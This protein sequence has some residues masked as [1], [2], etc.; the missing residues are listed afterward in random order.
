LC[1]NCQRQSCKAFIGLT[2]SEEMIGGDL[3][4]YVN[5][6]LSK[7]LLGAAAVLSRNL[8]IHCLEE[9]RLAMLVVCKQRSRDRNCTTPVIS[10][11]FFSEIF[12]WSDLYNLW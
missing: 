4:L 7:P 9:R 1:E 10:V 6:A 5:F 11:D 3:P 8:T 12:A 2:I